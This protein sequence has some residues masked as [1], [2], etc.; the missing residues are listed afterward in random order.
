MMTGYT[1]SGVPSLQDFDKSFFT[2]GDNV[3]EAFDTWAASV[4]D[5]YTLPAALTLDTE[6]SDEYSALFNDINTM[7]EERVGKFIT[8]ELDIETEW[9]A[10]QEDLISMGI[11]DCIAIY[12][13]AYDDYMASKG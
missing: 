7:A 4:D 8:G 13:E 12:Q 1:L 10:F 9:D 6:Q 11:E 2:Y 3:L 5:Q